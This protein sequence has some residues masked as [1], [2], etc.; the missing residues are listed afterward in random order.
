[1]DNEYKIEVCMNPHTWDNPKKPYFW[2]IFKWCTDAWCNEGSGWAITPEEVWEE[3]Y[4]FYI[5]FKP[6]K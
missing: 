3:A 6:E 1:M 4:D 5:R 2:C